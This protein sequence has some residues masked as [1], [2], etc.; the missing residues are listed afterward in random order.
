MMSVRV[1]LL[2]KRL[3]I[4]KGSFYWHFSG[5]EELLSAMIEEWERCQTTGVIA[6]VEDRGGSPHERFE[7][8][9]DALAGLDMGLEASIRSWA[10]SDR[11]ICRTIERVDAARLT[12]L[13]SIIES[14]GVPAAPAQARA[15]LVYFALIGELVTGGA[16]WLQRHRDA[17]DL[18]RSMILAWP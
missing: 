14:S 4:T 5:R 17:M 15:R 12:Y 13:Q 18:N 9:S 6:T 8:L 1:E 16:N 3:K 10:G 11:A 2:A 7:R